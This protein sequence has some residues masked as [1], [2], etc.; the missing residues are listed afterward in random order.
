VFSESSFPMKFDQALVA[1]RNS[2]LKLAAARPAPPTSA[3]TATTVFPLAWTDCAEHGGTL[4]ISLAL[5]ITE[6]RKKPFL[7]ECQA[8]KRK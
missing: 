5:L 8:T 1:L 2:P 6:P 4:R 7:A 3:M